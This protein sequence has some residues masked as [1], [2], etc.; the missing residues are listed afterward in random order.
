MRQT[1]DK[2]RGLHFPSTTGTPGCSPR[3]AG[4]GSWEKDCLDY[5]IRTWTGISR[6][7]QNRINIIWMILQ[8][9]V[10]PEIIIIIHNRD[11]NPLYWFSHLLMKRVQCFLCLFHTDD[12]DDVKWNHQ[13]IWRA[14]RVFREIHSSDLKHHLWTG[15]FQLAQKYVT[16]SE[17]L[18]ETNKRNLFLSRSGQ[19]IHTRTHTH[20]HVELNAWQTRSPPVFVELSISKLQKLC[21]K[22]HGRVE[23]PVKEY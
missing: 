19:C 1:Q 12:K 4:G 13:T 15:I 20:T 10:F 5:P 18:K 21:H 14:D 16:V 22:V 6:W 9:E 2:I 11:L 7:N 17:F 23:K 3:G 8:F